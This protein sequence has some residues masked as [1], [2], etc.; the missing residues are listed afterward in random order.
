M[1]LVKEV[2]T[3]LGVAG[4]YHRI[5]RFE[6]D[7][8]SKVLTVCLAIYPSEEARKAGYQPLWHDYVQLS[9]E[10]LSEDPRALLYPILATAEG[11]YLK[12][13]TSE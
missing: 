3:P 12:E 11:S 4:T 6:Y 8:T 5:Q 7:A 1:A 10:A 9:G 13:A 2:Q